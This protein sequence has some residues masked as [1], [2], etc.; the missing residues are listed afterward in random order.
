MSISN[1]YG[2]TGWHSQASSRKEGRGIRPSVYNAVIGAG[3]LP[4]V[5]IFTGILHLAT[6]KEKQSLATRVYLIIRGVLEIVGL[7]SLLLIP[8]LI[9]S[10]HRH[11]CAKA[12]H[13]HLT[14]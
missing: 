8:D 11:F 1:I 13:S 10:I 3:Y 6:A 9:V 12:Q 14:R 2:F 4:V 5:G 7:G